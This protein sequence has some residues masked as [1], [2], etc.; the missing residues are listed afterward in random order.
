[1]SIL[2]RFD[3]SRG[4][5]PPWVEHAVALTR[6]F[7]VAALVLIPTLGAASVGIVASWAPQSA[8]QMAETSTAFLQGI[9]DALYGLIG[10][11]A[12]GYSAAK[13]FEVVKAPPPPAGRRSPEGSGP[14]PETVPAGEEGAAPQLDP[15]NQ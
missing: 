5:L 4:V 2:D 1:M 13:S 12:L 14:R 3:F 7:G 9:P 8:M 10:A 15:E 11:V 6:P